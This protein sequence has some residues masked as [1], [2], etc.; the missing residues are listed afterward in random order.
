MANGQTHEQFISKPKPK[1]AKDYYNLPEYVEKRL[2]QRKL[3]KDRQTYT[4]ECGVKTISMMNHL[5]SIRHVNA[6]MKRYPVEI[7]TL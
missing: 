2:E 6:M 3:Y 5:Q 1:T 4:C 7:K